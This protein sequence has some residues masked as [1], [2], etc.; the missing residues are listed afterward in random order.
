MCIPCG[1]VVSVRIAVGNSR[2][3]SAN[4]LGLKSNELVLACTPGNAK[5]ATCR[6][7]EKTVRITGV[8]VGRTTVTL[9]VQ[10]GTK[11]RSIPINVRVV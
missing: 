7:T 1:S 11:F 3:L 10:N 8:S 2:T 5:I 9:R 4:T 6:S